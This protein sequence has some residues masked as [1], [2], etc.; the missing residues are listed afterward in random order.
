MQIKTTVRYYFLPVR[1]AIIKKTE[2]NGCCKDVEKLEPLYTL[3][4]VMQNGAFA[5]KIVWR[6]LKR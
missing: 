1:I 4:V 3:L 2:D 5:V 6:F